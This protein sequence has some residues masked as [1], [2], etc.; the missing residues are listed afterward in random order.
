[1]DCHRIFAYG[2]LKSDQLRGSMWPRRPIR[3]E[4]AITTGELWDLGSY[5]GLSV[6]SELILG[7]VWTFFHED[8][9]TTL[10]V[11][12]GI[13]GYD[14]SGDCGMYLRRQIDVQILDAKKQTQGCHLSSPIE[15]VS[16]ESVSVESVSVESVSVESVSV[17]SVSVKC[18]V[19]VIADP[20]RW[21]KARRIEPWYH[22][23]WQ[24]ALASWPDSQSRVPKHLSQEE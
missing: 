8:M 4:P 19:Y 9:D 20:S 22:N 3:I 12:D 16:V 21:P 11:L 5:P 6:G 23:R 18:F 24:T 13:E 15:S 7:E 17:E 14:P 1:M 2:T 10:D